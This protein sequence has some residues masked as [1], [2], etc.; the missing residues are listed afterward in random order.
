MLHGCHSDRALPGV[1]E[2]HRSNPHPHRNI[3]CRL[4]EPARPLPAYD[5]TAEAELDLEVWSTSPLGREDAK[6]VRLD[7]ATAAATFSQ[8]CAQALGLGVHLE[9]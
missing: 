1:R 5:R 9:W 8:T 2:D 7:P 3:P 4:R 6:I